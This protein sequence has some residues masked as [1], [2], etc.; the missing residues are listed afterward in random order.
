M[1]EE[2]LRIGKMGGKIVDIQPLGLS[3][4]GEDAANDE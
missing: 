2:M 1:N 3:S 4:T